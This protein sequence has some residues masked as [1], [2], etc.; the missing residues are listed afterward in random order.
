M[1]VGEE[2]RTPIYYTI[3]YNPD[4]KDY[5][6]EYLLSKI[7][8]KA[9]KKLLE[10]DKQLA[11]V[12]KHYRKAKSVSKSMNIN[13]KSVDGYVDV[14]TKN[15][16]KCNN[17]S[18]HRAVVGV[19]T[20]PSTC[21][22]K[23]TIKKGLS[24]SSSWIL[25]GIIANE[26]PKSSS[27]YSDPTAYGWTGYGNA[28]AK[29]RST[30]LPLKWQN[31]DICTLELSPTLLILHHKRG[32][33]PEKEYKMTIPK[34][35]DWRLHFNTYYKGTEFTYYPISGFRSNTDENVKIKYNL[36]LLNMFRQGKRD[37]MKNVKKDI[38]YLRNIKEN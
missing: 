25:M 11:L 14:E 36:L 27:S 13:V 30:S 34:R 26:N 12:E 16:V 17:S 3:L 4:N 10:N 8:N 24:G 31:G 37:N 29:G 9:D 15:I 6:A 1:K 32:N 18:A 19:D 22:W 35:N 28:Y 5:I 7:A 38:E 20:L 21:K 2:G 23:V 33:Q